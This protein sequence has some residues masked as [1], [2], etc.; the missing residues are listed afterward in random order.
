MEYQ[1][2][3][4]LLASFDEGFSSNSTPANSTFLVTAA[5]CV[6]ALSDFTT[7]TLYCAGRA[8]QDTEE[9]NAMIANLAKV[10]SGSAL[11]V[12]SRTP[13]A[14]AKKE[15]AP[16]PTRTATAGTT[17]ASAAARKPLRDA[18]KITNDAPTAVEVVASV[19][20]FEKCWHTWVL[21][22]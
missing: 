14:P 12:P 17:P 3:E 10:L 7:P 13:T 2:M 20:Y 22:W 4:Q 5:S 16:Q 11:E 6:C 21:T 15:A 19:S 9:A 1:G 8:V 18:L